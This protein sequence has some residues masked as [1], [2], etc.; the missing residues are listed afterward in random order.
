M[1]VQPQ[2]KTLCIPEYKEYSLKFGA[3]R[4]IITFISFYGKFEKFA[5]KA[6][7][8]VFIPKQ[9]NFLKN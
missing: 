4:L 3:N 5:K 6:T 1:V 8:Y 2:N 7:F 9:T